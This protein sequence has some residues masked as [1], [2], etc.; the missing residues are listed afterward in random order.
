MVHGLPD[1][2][3][4]SIYPVGS[5]DLLQLF[6]AKLLNLTM[7]VALIYNLIPFL[8]FTVLTYYSIS[9]IIVLG[10]NQVMG[11]KTDVV[12]IGSN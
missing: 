5:P 12:V 4:R 11:T 8:P 1:I 7:V 9:T 2:Y 6:I 10:G 3:V